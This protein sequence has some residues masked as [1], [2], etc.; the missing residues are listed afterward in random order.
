[1]GGDLVAGRRLDRIRPD[2]WDRERG[3]LIR[4]AV[5]RD[6]SQAVPV[7][8]SFVGGTGKYL[9]MT[10]NVAVPSERPSEARSA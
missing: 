1:M 9:G 2:T 7:A 10:V 8:G 3:N 4:V 6:I 5:T